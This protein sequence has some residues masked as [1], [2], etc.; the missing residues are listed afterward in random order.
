MNEL[1]QNFAATLEPDMKSK[2]LGERRGKE[3]WR[4]TTAK[5]T[6]FNSLSLSLRRSANSG[7]RS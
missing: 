4:A 6:G 7:N 5:F 2:L 1:G 3:Y